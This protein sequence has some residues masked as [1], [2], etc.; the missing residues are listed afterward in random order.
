[1]D[2]H[3]KIARYLTY[4]LDKKFGI[5]KFRFGL[6]AIIG[7]IPGIGDIFAFI[8]SSYLVW[9]GIRINLPPDQIALMIRNIVIDLVLGLIPVVG[10]LSDFVYKAN[11]KNYEILERFSRKA[12]VLEGEVIKDTR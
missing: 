6:D 9:I 2:K 8:V 10:D 1:M 3:L 7:L 4:N 11:S 5:G 12:A